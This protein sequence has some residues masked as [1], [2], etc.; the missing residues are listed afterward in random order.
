M[1]NRRQFVRRVPG[2]GAFAVSTQSI[3]TQPGEILDWPLPPPAAGGSQDESFPTQH[4]FLAKEMVG[5]AHGNIARV[6]ELLSRHST[7][8]KASWDWGY[9]DWETALGAAS[10]VGNR[11]IAEMLVEHGAPPTI[12]SAAMLGQ[13]DVVKAFAGAVPNVN[14]LR[15]PHGIPLINHARAGG[16]GAVEVLKY[17][18]SLGNLPKMGDLDVLTDADRTAIEGRYVFGSRPRDSFIVNSEKNLIGITRV[19]AARRPMTYLGRLEFHPA[20]AAAV[21]IRFAR[22]ETST[23]LAIFDPDL[24]V[25]AVRQR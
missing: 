21:R 5:V 2:L 18:E 7:L 3:N 20:G 8:A 24:V 13:L 12:F 25:R 17:L 10:H 19:G 15:G 16:A 6:K 11:P 4:P 9:G 22:S 14:Q 1:I 23:T